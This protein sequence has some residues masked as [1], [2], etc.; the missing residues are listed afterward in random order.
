MWKQPLLAVL[1]LVAATSSSA[2]S[3]PDSLKQVRTYPIEFFDAKGQKAAIAQL[4]WQVEQLEATRQRLRQNLGHVDEMFWKLNDKQSALRDRISGPWQFVSPEVR[5]QLAGRCAEQL[6]ELQLEAASLQS[7]EE[8][9]DAAKIGTAD[10]KAE[11]ELVAQE[12]KL[13]LEAAFH[14]RSLLIQKVKRKSEQVNAG[15]S[16]EEELTE[17]EL[18]LTQIDPLIKQLELKLKSIMAKTEKGTAHQLQEKLLMMSVKE[19]TIIARQKALQSFLEELA[20]AASQEQ[21]IRRLEREQDLLFE[22][23]SRLAE[24]IGEIEM[25]M[26]ESRA[27][28]ELYESRAKAGASK[29]NSDNDTS[30]EETE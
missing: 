1:L 25:E 27:L 17:L 6:L 3:Q 18:Q 21:E 28:L 26:Y 4:A 11:L 13:Q 9:Q 20:G 15:F 16:P 7:K 10:E 14:E 19:K 22:K 5:S 8:L 2:F 23:Q 29:S 30:A 12:L 24:R